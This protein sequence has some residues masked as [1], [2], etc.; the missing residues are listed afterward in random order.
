VQLSGW[1]HQQQARFAAATALI[2]GQPGR[3]SVIVADRTTGAEWRAGEDGLRTWGGSTPKLALAVH[4]LE[5]ARA[6]HLTLDQRDQANIDAMLSVSDNA[7]AN[8]LWARHVDPSTVMHRWQSSYGMAEASYVEGFP[9]TWGFVKLTVRDL[10]NLMAYVLDRLY[11]TDRAGVVERMRTV[12]DAQQWGVWGAGAQRRPGV[13]NGWDYLAEAGSD[14]RRWVTSTVGFVGPGERHIVAALYDQPPGDLRSIQ[15]GVHLLT[16][17]VAT[18]FGAPVP[19]PAV[20]P[21]DY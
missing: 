21:Q 11:P 2:A 3:L 19:A 18:L 8:E 9:A 4:L 16:D 6:G 10:A 17:L 12:G 7:A 20:V 13:K 5:Q 15:L 14:Q 1:E